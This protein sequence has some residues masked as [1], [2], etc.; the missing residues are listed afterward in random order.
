[1]S[2]RLADDNTAELRCELRFT[3]G[4]LKN[5]SIRAVSDIDIFEDKPITGDSCALTLYFASRGESLWD[6]AKAH[7]TRLERL[8]SE[9][10]ADSI[11]LGEPQMLL[12][13]GI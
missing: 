6:I 8:I 5:E 2:Y 4:A 1:M 10:S 12:I 13:P 9:N 3:A 11:T 7:N